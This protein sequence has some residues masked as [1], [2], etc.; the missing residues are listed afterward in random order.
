MDRPCSG[1]HSGCA[2]MLRHIGPGDAVHGLGDCRSACAVAVK[3]APM[4]HRYAAE[5]LDRSAQPIIWP[6]CREC[7]LRH[8]EPLSEV[9]ARR[10][11]ILL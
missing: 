5:G 9:P 2:R 3:P 8:L 1:E 11:E 10:E 7:D 6:P 4:A